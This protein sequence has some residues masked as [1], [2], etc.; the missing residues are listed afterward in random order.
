V[1]GKELIIMEVTSVKLLDLFEL[2]D[3]AIIY[4]HQSNKRGCQ[5]QN[6]D[7]IL[8]ELKNEYYRLSKQL[9]LSEIDIKRIEAIYELAQYD[10]KL[11]L[12]IN[13]VDNLI[14]WELDLNE[15]KLSAEIIEQNIK[16]FVG[17][18]PD[19]PGNV[20][21]IPRVTRDDSKSDL[22]I[23]FDFQV[24]FERLY[25]KF[26]VSE[27]QSGGQGCNGCFISTDGHIVTNAHVNTSTIMNNKGNNSQWDNSDSTLLELFL[28]HS[29]E[30]TKQ[31][32]QHLF[33]NLFEDVTSTLGVAGDDSKPNLEIVFD[34]R[35]EFERLYSKFKVGEVLSGGQ[36]CLTQNNFEVNLHI[37][38]GHSTKLSSVKPSNILYVPGSS[39]KGVL[40]DA[41]TCCH[42]KI[43]TWFTNYKSK[44]PTAWS[45]YANDP[46]KNWLLNNSDFSIL[47]PSAKTSLP[48]GQSSGMVDTLFKLVMHHGGINMNNSVIS[49]FPY[50][51]QAQLELT[52][53]YKEF[54][55]K[56]YS[57]GQCLSLNHYA[58]DFGETY[59]RVGKVFA[60]LGHF[61]Y[62]G[63][64]K[65]RDENAIIIKY[66]N[67]KYLSQEADA[68]N[69]DD[70]YEQ[71]LAQ[72]AV[73]WSG[74]HNTQWVTNARVK[75][76]TI[77]NSKG[78]NSQ[79]DNSDSTLLELVQEYYRLSK[80]LEPNKNDIRHIEAIYELA[81]Y[82][83]ELNSL[84]NKVD[85]LIAS[86]LDFT[87]NFSDIIPSI[88]R[89]IEFEKS[90]EFQSNSSIL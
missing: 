66:S 15:D 30:I 20:T 24:E 65:D 90:T 45:Y 44:L 53:S 86:E 29:T 17:H 74:H 85:N 55:Y 18:E 38:K 51:I 88:L 4:N 62:T 60:T 54:L 7:T 36:G 84:I 14:A 34:F 3:S 32:I 89:M 80:I 82:D 33:A 63:W 87:G 67:G 81:Q 27:V 79:W 13:E 78:K 49:Y 59:K 83:P 41:L 16:H 68:M 70:K 52:Q 56:F 26:K 25:S 69:E 64:R 58:V 73:P 8:Y 77:M 2:I 28:K 35:D 47:L 19:L 23:V 6:G 42:P 48:Y 75:Q 72:Q 31:K 71:K 40:R 1:M 22:E 76:F 37:F 9:E 12:L 10:P 50:G 57:T 61:V 39:I 46:D 21:N 5:C 11:N 43:P